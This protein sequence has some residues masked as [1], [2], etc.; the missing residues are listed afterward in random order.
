M[1]ELAADWPWLDQFFFKSPLFWHTRLKFGGIFQCKKVEFQVQ[2]VG[3]DLKWDTVPL[4]GHFL[5]MA[6][7]TYLSVNVHS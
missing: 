1:R 2:V 5:Y 4:N 7:I 6:T 3:L